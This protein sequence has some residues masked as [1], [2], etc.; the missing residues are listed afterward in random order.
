MVG[1][2][3]QEDI[4]GFGRLQPPSQVSLH[5]GSGEGRLLTPLWAQRQPGSPMPL[6]KTAKVDRCGP[7][8]GA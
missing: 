5:D 2:L 8:Q 3:G 1:W 4:I 7:Q 6:G